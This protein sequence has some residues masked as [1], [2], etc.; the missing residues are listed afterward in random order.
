MGLNQC[1][2]EQKVGSLPVLVR[3]PSQ[4][5][6]KYDADES[7]QC[8]PAK[9]TEHAREETGDREV[10]IELTKVFT[11]KRANETLPHHP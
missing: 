5:Q 1:V 3:D 11:Y 6:V 8:L 9:K 7:N 2:R 10:A 4:V